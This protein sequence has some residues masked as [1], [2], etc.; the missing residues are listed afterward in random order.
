MVNKKI[1]VV[2]GGISGLVLSYELLKKGC[3]VV[4]I[5]KSKYLGGLARSFKWKGHDVDLGPHIYHTPHKDILNYWKKEFKNLL[6]PKKHWAKNYKNNRFYDYPISKEFILSLGK[7]VSNKIFKELESCKKNNLKNSKNYYEYTLNLAGPTL[8]KLFFTDYPKKLWGLD[9]KK[10]DANWAPKRVEV[11]DKR[12]PFYDKQFSAVGIKGSGSII[13]ELENKALKKGL[14][15]IFRNEVKKFKTNENRITKIKLKNKE[16]TVEKNDIVINTTSLTNIS[17]QFNINCNLRFRGIKLVFLLVKNNKIFPNK[18]DFVYFD[19]PKIIFNRVSNQNSFIKNPV[20]ETTVLCFEITY[21]KNDKIDKM[22]E[23]EIMNRVIKDFYNLSFVSK[24]IVKSSKLINLPE[25]YPFYNRGYQSELSS[26]K[27]KL[28]SYSNAYFLGSLAEFAYNDIQILFGKAIDLADFLTSKTIESNKINKMN[29]TKSFNQ[30]FNL[31]ENLIGSFQNVFIIAE[32]G[33]NHNGDINLAKRLIEEAKKSGANAIKFQSFK[34]ENRVSKIGK[35]SRYV[36]KIL[37]IEETDYEMLKKLELTKLQMK[38]LIN[39]A[40]KVGIDIFTAPF[41]LET[42]YELEK[43]QIPYYKIASFDITN[44]D[45]IAAVASTKKPI[46]ISTGM[47]NLSEIE[48]AVETVSKQQNN[49]LALLQCTS[50]YPTP[51]SNI[52]LKAIDTLKNAFKVPV[53]LSDHSI[54]V[55]IPIAAA[56]RGASIIEKHFT[57]DNSMEGPDHILSLNPSNFLDMVTKIR[58]VEQSLGDGVK[59]VSPSE[60]RT[61]MRFKKTCYTNCDIKKGEIITDKKIILK[62]PA[63]GIA[64]KYKSVINGMRANK[65]IKKDTPIIWEDIS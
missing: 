55:E 42:F 32:A 23:K 53:G 21:S 46:I 10:L 65:L 8:Q 19:D 4:L 58:N 54:G 18:T 9:T 43:L 5:E 24:G 3:E 6:F 25:V 34:A 2:G 13:N 28:E 26:I 30:N 7:D 15:I 41:D 61:I 56:A 48:E 36:E 31:K 44:L 50:N 47:S 14:K 52:N 51:F 49:K 27:S 39:H 12:K 62:G 1:Y 11:R 64:P 63:Y 35:T 40:R 38:T 17:N 60:F 37:G 45:L 16:I 29:T 20:R 22:S 33:L 57:L 59:R